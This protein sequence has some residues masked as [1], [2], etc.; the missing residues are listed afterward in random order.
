M[1]NNA[2]VDVVSHNIQVT[3][4]SR[5][6]F[7]VLG[8]EVECLIERGRLALMLFEKIAHVAYLRLLMVLNPALVLAIPFKVRRSRLRGNLRVD[9][10]NRLHDYIIKNAHC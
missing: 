8:C 2:L 3:V 7:L 5:C 1:H 6:T 4:F 10:Y 9:V